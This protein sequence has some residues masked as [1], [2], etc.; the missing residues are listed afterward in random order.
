M[1]VEYTPAGSSSPWKVERFEQ[2]SSQFGLKPDELSQWH[3]ALHDI[4]GFQDIRKLYGVHPILR[5]ID[6]DPKEFRTWDIKELSIQLLEDESEI[7]TR[8]NL[9]Q[10]VW[11]KIQ[12]QLERNAL[13]KPKP[14]RRKNEPEPPPEPSAPK[15]PTA[16]PSQLEMTADLQALLDREGYTDNYFNSLQRDAKDAAAEKLWFANRLSDIQEFLSDPFTSSL[17]REALANEIALRRINSKLMVL[18]SDDPKY[19]LLHEKKNRH[20][21]AMQSQWEKIR[22]HN[23]KATQR[24]RQRQV[25]GTIG[26]MIEAVRDFHAN[27][28]NELV[29]GFYNAFEIQILLREAEQR[30]IQYRLGQVCFFNEAM[31]GKYD[32]NFKRRF[33]N[34]QCKALDAGFKEAASRVFG[35]E[36]VKPVDMENDGAAGEFPKLHV[37]PEEEEPAAPTEPTDVIP[38]DEHESIGPGGE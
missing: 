15:I 24:G 28:N 4:E 11:K 16:T 25:I 6:S 2:L 30:P 23:P 17:I 33:T 38:I 5:P 21:K 22:E 19:D 34:A 14:K 36:G 8:V 35:E 13:M 31:A 20:E 3:A 12:L 27:K 1:S 18:E 26:G 10:T 7:L 37:P 9:V 32:P 29:D